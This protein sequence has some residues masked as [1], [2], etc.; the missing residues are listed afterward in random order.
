MYRSIGPLLTANNTA[1]LAC[2]D[3]PRTEQER[4]GIRDSKKK[5]F[6]RQLFEA[7]T[8]AN[9]H[10]SDDG[11][12]DDIE[13]VGS[14][15]VPK[16]PFSLNVDTF[17]IPGPLVLQP[18]YD[19]ELEDQSL[20]RIVE[21][22]PDRQC[23]RGHRFLR[24]NHPEL[25]MTERQNEVVQLVKVDSDLETQHNL[26]LV[27][28]RHVQR[29]C[30]IILTNQ[31]YGE[32]SYRKDVK[33]YDHKDLDN[34][35]FFC[36]WRSAEANVGIDE[37]D[38]LGPPLFGKIEH[39]RFEDADNGEIITKSIQKIK[40][41]IPDSDVRKQWRGE[42]H[43]T[44][45][46]S[47]VEIWNGI[48]KRRYTFGD[49]FAGAGGTSSG[50]LAAQLKMKFAFDLD[51]GAC[52]TYK[53]NFQMTELVMQ[54]DVADFI[55]MAIAQLNRFLVDLLHMSPPCQPF[56]GS[57]R[58]PN[59]E[60]DQKNLEA[61]G[62]VPHLLEVCKPRIAT[63][64]EAKSLTDKDK[65]AHFR[66]LISSFI[67]K[68][69]SVQWKAV[70]LSTFG[71]PQT[72]KRTI[73]IASGP[74]EKLPSFAK[75]THGDGPGLQPIPTINS[76]INAIPAN[77]SHHNDIP[78]MMKAQEPYDGNILCRTILTAVK[79]HHYHPNGLRRFSIREYAAIQTFPHDFSFVS[80]MGAALKQIGNAVPP[81]FAA[82]MYRHI[83]GELTANDV[84]EERPRGLGVERERAGRRQTVILDLSE[85]AMDVD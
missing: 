29:N 70:D 77:A 14:R 33:G 40:F 50:A 46:G 32:L 52:R 41:Q 59:Q 65:R 8:N 53:A 3:L 9:S 66:Q 48:Q 5:P 15:P 18:G 72:R 10:I 63:L 45:R 51:E 68:G 69:Y 60:Q 49:A 61:F 4:L 22:L 47:H 81:T 27:E 20:L 23:I 75:P 26:F 44:L 13:I 1:Q 31:R 79:P 2:H 76:T 64:E 78:G 62:K 35:I 57:N 56:C 82:T 80:D 25:F 74:G 6:H 83:V 34:P 24:Q 84:A 73:I 37:K 42:A 12:D 55:P 7:Y 43:S 58:T 16:F 11:G 71:V 21:Y 38:P 54:A 85:E 67:K 17:A 19:V 28:V 36:R 39:L 30:K